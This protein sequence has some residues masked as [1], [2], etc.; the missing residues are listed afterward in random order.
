MAKDYLET[1]GTEDML[2]VDHDEPLWCDNARTSRNSSG[3]SVA[4]TDSLICSETGQVTLH[5]VSDLR[6]QLEQFRLGR[7]TPLIRV[8]S[9]VPNPKSLSNRSPVAVDDELRGPA[10]EWL[11]VVDASPDGQVLT[12]QCCDSGK[13]SKKTACAVL[14][15]INSH[16]LKVHRY[17]MPDIPPELEEDPCVFPE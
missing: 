6:A 3:S 13:V 15:D 14:D 7:G 11:V 12:L 4:A 2:L 9:E 10:G 1:G 16:R 8:T 17:G 5:D